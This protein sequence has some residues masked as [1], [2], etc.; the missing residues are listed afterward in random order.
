MLGTKLLS[1]VVFLVR[2]GVKQIKGPEL[3]RVGEEAVRNLLDLSF[4][5]V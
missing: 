3:T 5:Q 2:D 4:P 1:A